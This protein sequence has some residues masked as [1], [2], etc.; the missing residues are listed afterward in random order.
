MSVESH[1][2]FSPPAST[3]RSPPPSGTSRDLESQAASDCGVIP[4]TKQKNSTT[5][6]TSRRVRGKRSSRRPPARYHLPEG[7]RVS[8]GLSLSIMEAGY[9]P[10]TPI[11]HRSALRRGGR[12][13]EEASSE[14]SAR[15]E[16][17]PVRISTSRYEK[18]EKLSIPS[19]TFDC[20][21]LL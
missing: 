12:S 4:D 5:A 3:F 17:Q 8:A 20:S 19:I 9:A 16:M 21:I 13:I 14:G 10:Y 18:R 1:R 2:Q 15:R 7:R 6:S 11:S